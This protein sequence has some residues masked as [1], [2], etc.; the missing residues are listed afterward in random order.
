MIYLINKNNDDNELVIFDIENSILKN[1][2]KEIQY[3]LFKAISYIQKQ[4][5]RIFF[6]YYYKKQYI[7]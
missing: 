7:G 4:N 5:D 1:V 2:D 3:K 6:K